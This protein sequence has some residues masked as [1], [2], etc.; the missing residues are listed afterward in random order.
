M[1]GFNK[2][3]QHKHESKTQLLK[4]CKKWIFD[5]NFNDWVE[6]EGELTLS[7]YISTIDLTTQLKMKIK[8]QLK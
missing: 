7:F 1:I 6:I 3:P 5:S 2:P 4:K 8:T